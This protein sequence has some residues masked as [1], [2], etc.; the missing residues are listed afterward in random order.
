MRWKTQER[1]A[2]CF[3]AMACTP[4]LNE[5]RNDTP[6]STF[7][8]LVAG[9]AVSYRKLPYWN[10]TPACSVSCCPVARISTYRRSTTP[11]RT[12]G[13]V[14]PGTRVFTDDTTMCAPY[15]SDADVRLPANTTFR[16][17]RPTTVRR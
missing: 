6:S 17:S 1:S 13:A 7:T 2:T 12:T 9:M 11:A 5:S 14:T 3:A 15:V 16:D 4:V 8:G 10:S